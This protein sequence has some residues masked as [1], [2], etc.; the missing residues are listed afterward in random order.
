MKVTTK[1]TTTLLA[2]TLLATA[3]V[4]AVNADTSSSSTQTEQSSTSTSTSLKH[5]YVVYGAGVS[6]SEYSKIN[7]VLGVDSSFKQLTATASDYAKYLSASDKSSTTDANMISSVAIAPADPGSGVKVNIKKYNGSQN[8]TSVTARQYALVAQMAGVTNV[9]IEVTANRAVSGQAALAGVY[10]ALAAAGVS[11]N[12][13]S[14]KAA[15]QVLTATTTAIKAQNNNTSY[16]TKL[17]TAVGTTSKQI[18]QKKQAGTTLT[19]T[20]I[21]VLLQANLKKQNISTKTSTTVVNNLTTALVSFQKTSTASSKSYAKQVDAT[22]S[23]IKQT[24]SNVMNTAKDWATSDTT[25]A[26]AAQAKQTTK[27]WWDTIVAWVKNV[28]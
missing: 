6:S 11:V 16:A 28:F 21:K 13:T 8:I 22:L 10:K 26:V 15:N 23:N 2:T 19:K 24:T 20:E 5:A 14:T 25:K 9:T 12:T 17:L 18:A 4:P 1:I 3:A 27:S 7:K